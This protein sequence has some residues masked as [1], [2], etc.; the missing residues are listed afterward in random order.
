MHN[1]LA[2]TET[3]RSFSRLDWIAAFLSSSLAVMRRI[4][5]PASRWLS[6][7]LSFAHSQ[8]LLRLPAHL[9]QRVNEIV[10]R[11]MLFRL[12]PHPHERV[13]QIVNYFLLSFGHASLYSVSKHADEG[14]QSSRC[15]MED[16]KLVRRRVFSG[17]IG[18]KMFYRRGPAAR[19]GVS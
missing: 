8:L 16:A 17:M 7:W 12:A 6:L 1:R 10:N 14:V 3:S 19:P 15:T 18:N 5:S 2:V 9:H 11:F 4:R 13:E